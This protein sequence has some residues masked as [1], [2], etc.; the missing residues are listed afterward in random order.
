MKQL[1]LP[2]GES[3]YYLDRMTALYVF[4]EIFVDNIYLQNNIEIKD[5]NIIFDVGANI[6]LFSRF[7]SQ[8]ASN[9]RIFTFEPIP[10]IF[11]VLETNLENIDATI[12]NYNIGLGEQEEKIKFFYYP[13]ISA[14][15]T[16]VPFEW[17]K[18]VEQYLEN[19]DEVIC[20]DFPTAR[21]VPEFS[22][23][24]F[25]EKILK[26]LYKAKKIIGRIRPLSDIIKENNLNNIDLLKIDAEN[27]E[28]HVLAG[29][30]NED[31]N[32][33][34]QISMEVHEHIKG[35]E[36]LLKKISES[37]KKRGFEIDIG[38]E[39]RETKMGVYMLY[40]KKK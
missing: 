20:K 32:K 37:L 9:L 22:R 3:I 34:Q 1:T 28:K 12:K 4:Q 6:G 18:K 25:V 23:K 10:E 7:I 24:D 5:N 36:N 26:H 31:W 16:A 38:K 39:S 35:G 17:N 30:R 2:N 33:I 13:K 8:K 11:N 19:Y 14:D 40:A 21:N 29:I 27:Y 15:S